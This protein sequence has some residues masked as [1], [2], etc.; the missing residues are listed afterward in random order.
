MT[1]V[2]YDSGAGGLSVL[3]KIVQ[4]KQYHHI[5]YIADQ[6]YAPYG[7]KS[8]R[9][10]YLRI[11]KIIQHVKNCYTI[12]YWF[13]G[14]FTAAW[15]LLKYNFFEEHKHDDIIY[16]HLIDSLNQQIEILQKEQQHS[17]LLMTP[18]SFS[19]FEDKNN[20]NSSITPVACIDWATWIE[21]EIVYKKSEKQLRISVENLMNTYKNY[22]N[23]IFGC[24]HYNFIPQTFFQKSNTQSNNLTPV[25]YDIFDLCNL[26][27]NS[28]ES[29]IKKIS[30]MTTSHSISD[31]I[32]YAHFCQDFL[33]NY[34]I[35]FK[36]III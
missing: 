31:I 26:C 17:L 21:Q 8:T 9:E 10:I 23:I 5:I 1:L 16:Y 24:T 27:F 7:S 14:C 35:D 32:P 12:H 18:L 3:K 34:E 15:A 19:C 22:K 13:F 33:L 25:F 2:I 11:Q 36:N 6:A 28:S 4:K 20:N 29:S 30:F